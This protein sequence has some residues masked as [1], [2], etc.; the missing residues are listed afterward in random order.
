MGALPP[1]RPFTVI[2]RLDDT[3]TLLKTAVMPRERMIEIVPFEHQRRNAQGLLP[4]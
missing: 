3:A 1:A 4:Y 2:T